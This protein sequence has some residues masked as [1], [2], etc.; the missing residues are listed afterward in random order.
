MFCTRYVFFFVFYCSEI[1]I[2]ATLLL[3]FQKWD[4]PTLVL[5]ST[6]TTRPKQKKRRL[7]LVCSEVRLHIVL[8]THSFPV[9][10]L[11]IN[12]LSYKYK[13]CILILIYLNFF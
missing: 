9:R 7:Y 1:I 4:H 10:L 5:N 2:G 13:S 3:N 6:T 8:M 12:P 11:S